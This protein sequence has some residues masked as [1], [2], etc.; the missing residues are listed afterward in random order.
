M[1][2]RSKR[3]ESR[4]AFRIEHGLSMSEGGLRQLPKVTHEGL[5]YSQGVRL[6]VSLGSVADLFCN[7]EEWADASD[8][9]VVGREQRL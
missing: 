9:D 3:C 2:I 4:R 6:A 1:A 5:H 8:V 7:P